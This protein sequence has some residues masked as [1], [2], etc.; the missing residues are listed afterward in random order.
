[1]ISE[2]TIQVEDLLRKDKS[3][4]PLPSEYP[5]PKPDPGIRPCAKSDLPVMPLFQTLLMGL[6]DAV[7]SPALKRRFEAAVIGDASCRPPVS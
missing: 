6:H 5:I 4:Y 1:M 2:T 7:D 3:L